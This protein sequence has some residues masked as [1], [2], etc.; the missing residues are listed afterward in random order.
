[1]DKKLMTVS[2]RLVEQT[3]KQHWKGVK[4]MQLKGK[5]A[6]I[7][8]SGRG[9]GKAMAVRM[10]RE[11]ASVVVNDVNVA[12]MDT[13]VKEIQSAG[14]KAIGFK[15]D[16]TKR[17]EI[18]DMVKAAIDKFGKIDIWVNN[19]GITRHRPSFMELG[20]R[21][22]R[23]PQGCIQLHKGSGAP[24]DGAAVWQDNQ[25]LILAGNWSLNRRGR[26]QLQLWSRQGRSSPDD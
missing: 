7:T 17:A 24:H 13:T 2:D 12:D 10:A 14:G 9:M 11:G 16:V 8:G 1:V 19:A 3:A 25:Y 22:G 21:S 26:R 18:A 23:R 4:E 20:R 5:V 6:V 15:A